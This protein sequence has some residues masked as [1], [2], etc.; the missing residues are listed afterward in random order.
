MET[1]PVS[2]DLSAAQRSAS[3]GDSTNRDSDN[4]H[5]KGSYGQGLPPGKAMPPQKRLM[6]E[7]NQSGKSAYC[8]ADERG[9]H[10]QGRDGIV[11]L[12]SQSSAQVNL[13]KVGLG[14]QDV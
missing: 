7:E 13:E 11:N 12:R 4:E 8:S 9:D 5:Q 10:R 3:S 6:E 2:L 14:V 1:I